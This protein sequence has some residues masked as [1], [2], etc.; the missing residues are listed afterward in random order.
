MTPWARFTKKETLLPLGAALFIAA[1]FARV[2]LGMGWPA[3]GFCLVLICGIE[4]IS[5]AKEWWQAR[6]K[7]KR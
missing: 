6:T 7:R 4:L 2:T 1:Y 5:F 3:I